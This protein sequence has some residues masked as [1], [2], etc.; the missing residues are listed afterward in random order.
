MISKEGKAK[1]LQQK[2]YSANPYK[3]QQRVAR[4]TNATQQHPLFVGLY[5]YPLQTTCM[6][7]SIYTSKTL[8]GPLPGSFGKNT[9][10]WFLAK[11]LPMCLLQQNILP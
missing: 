11:H 10:C 4:G 7:S 9:I 2:S 6:L 1:G 3:D 8:H 5:S